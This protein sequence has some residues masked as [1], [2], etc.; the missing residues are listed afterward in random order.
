MVPSDWPADHA[1]AG[2]PGGRRGRHA[3]VLPLNV[4][5]AALSRVHWEGL[6][7]DL[8]EMGAR[9]RHGPLFASHVSPARSIKVQ[10]C[11]TFTGA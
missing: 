4:E 1:A 7:H 9:E 8:L 5:V 11:I 6:D 2:P 10:T 3:A